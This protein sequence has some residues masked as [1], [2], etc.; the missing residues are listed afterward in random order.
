MILDLYSC[1]QLLLIQILQPLRSN[2]MIIKLTRKKSGDEM[3]KVSKL[4]LNQHNVGVW[5]KL[6]RWKVWLSDPKRDFCGVCSCTRLLRGK[7]LL[8]CMYVSV[9][10]CVCVLCVCVS[11]GER[12]NLAWCGWLLS[13]CFSKCVS[14][15]AH[16]WSHPMCLHE[17]LHTAIMT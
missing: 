4:L 14:P 2:Y 11:E 12:A 8:W 7:T 5:H 16:I 6:Y 3:W 15:S 10:V 9:C 17:C 1:V 13:V